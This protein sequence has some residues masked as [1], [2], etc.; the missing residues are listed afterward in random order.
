MVTLHCQKRL[1]VCSNTS[2][3]FQRLNYLSSN[4]QIWN[5]GNETVCRQPKVDRA[6]GY[7]RLLII[8]SYYSQSD[9]FLFY[10]CSIA[11]ETRLFIRTS[12]HILFLFY[13]PSP[14]PPLPPQVN[15][16]PM[17]AVISQTLLT[18]REAK[19]NIN[20]LPTYP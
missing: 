10:S 14:S 13:G 17:L 11:R 20:A 5:S 4:T 15:S 7:G 1:L 12:K 6:L 8:W 2:H 19:L 9:I 18:R 3:F 16:P